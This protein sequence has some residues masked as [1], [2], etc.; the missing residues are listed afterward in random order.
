MLVVDIPAWFERIMHLSGPAPARVPLYAVLCMLHKHCQQHSAQTADASKSVVMLAPL[1][2]CQNCGL[3]KFCRNPEASHV[4][5]VA[6]FLSCST[7]A[8]H[9]AGPCSA[10]KSRCLDSKVAW[11][12]K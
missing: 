9:Y 4:L 3:P 1:G 2:P 7:Q 10:N 11:H 6:G 5:V 12:Y 8:A